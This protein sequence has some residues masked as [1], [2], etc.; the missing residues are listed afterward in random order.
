VS[1]G[2]WWEDCNGGGEEVDGGGGIGEVDGGGG[3]SLHR[4]RIAQRIGT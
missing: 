1:A 2:Q 4:E 3:G